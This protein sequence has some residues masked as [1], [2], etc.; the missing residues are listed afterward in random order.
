M[1]M[2]FDKITDWGVAYD[3]RAAV[4]THEEYF[5]NWG[6]SA[7][8]FRKSNPGEEIAYGE[9]PR[10]RFDLFLPE[11][12]P[13]G[14]MVFIH[15]GWWMNFGREYFSHLA[16]G[17]LAHGW[18]VAVPSYTLAPEYRIGQ[19]VAQMRAAVTKAAR[20]V[21]DVPVTVCGHSA[22]GH[23]AAMMATE[24]GGLGADIRARL[25]RVISLSG[26]ADLR[27]LI[28][29]PIN[30]SLHVDAAEALR[31]S[32]LM[33]L[34]A[35]DTEVVAWVGADEVSEFRRQNAMLGQ[36]WASWCA[37]RIVEDAGHNH[38]DVMDPLIDPGSLMT[39]LAVLDE[40]I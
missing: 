13:K 5:L 25:K 38:F 34:P 31:I 35:G 3:N 17:P 1:D 9:H 16:Q 4:P 10:E 6:R 8:A 11:N 15:G 23:L 14:V 24:A 7:A 30:D 22:G 26:I 40:A 39:R 29:Q 27:A 21:P 19:I 18:A 28:G 36:V 12:P 32:P 33:H 37:M 2:Q 20:L